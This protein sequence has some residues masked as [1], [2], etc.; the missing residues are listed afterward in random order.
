MRRKKEFLKEKKYKENIK[1]KEEKCA[2]DDA[3]LVEHQ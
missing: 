1:K 2:G 3:A